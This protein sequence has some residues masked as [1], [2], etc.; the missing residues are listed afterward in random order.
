M[1]ASG[2]MLESKFEKKEESKEIAILARQAAEYVL[3]G[4]PDE[5]EI[6][7]TQNPTVLL[8]SVEVTGPNGLQR[9]TIYELALW[10]DDHHI[11]NKNGQT[12]VEMIRNA[13]LRLPGGREIEKAQRE[14]QYGD[15]KEVVRK[16]TAD[17]AAFNEV[18]RAFDDSTATTMDELIRDAKLQ[19]AIQKFKDYLKPKGII[20]QGISCVTELW[21]YAATTYDT[22]RFVKYGSPKNIFFCQH[23]ISAIDLRLPAWAM[24][25]LITGIIFVI[26]TN[27][28]VARSDVF[29]YFDVCLLSAARMSDDYFLSKYG[30]RYPIDK[31][32]DPWRDGVSVAPGNPSRCTFKAFIN[33]CGHPGEEVL[34]SVLPS[35]MEKKACAPA[36][37]HLKTPLKAKLL[38]APE[39]LRFVNKTSD[40]LA[41]KIFLAIHTF[42]KDPNSTIKQK[43]LND[44]LGSDPANIKIALGYEIE[45]EIP[46]FG[47]ARVTPLVYLI[48]SIK[49]PVDEKVIFQIIEAMLGRGADVNGFEDT[50]RR[51][52]DRM[53]SLPSLICAVAFC[54][55]NIV[56]FLLEHGADAARVN[57]M[58]NCT[59][60]TPLLVA[61][62]NYTKRDDKQDDKKIYDDMISKLLVHGALR[63]GYCLIQEGDQDNVVGYAATKGEI[64]LVKR[65][66]HANELFYVGENEA[67]N[68]KMYG[69]RTIIKNAAKDGCTPMHRAA[70]KGYPEILE[71]LL[72]YNV[73]NSLNG[74]TR[75]DIE[76]KE[77][78]NLWDIIDNIDKRDFG[79]DSLGRTPEERIEALKRLKMAYATPAELVQQPWNVRREAL[80]ATYRAKESFFNKEPAV[81]PGVV[82]SPPPSGASSPGAP[83]AAAPA[84][85]S[86]TA[87]PPR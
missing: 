2:T 30:D 33:R 20:T 4:A 7:I 45:I 9:G 36:G 49:E 11:R 78:E 15:C 81:C 62:V 85:P 18:V 16:I 65:L 6:I 75:A 87:R 31:R 61:V 40:V 12:L 44:L 55:P 5:V 14:A 83:P 67:D 68:D 22:E 48:C 52:S 64:E 46:I 70:L 37:S 82:L 32:A 54:K 77:G 13:V 84:A 29:P 58:R 35:G 42:L 21:D 73:K 17:R 43:E 63:T 80:L 25:V 23:I 53:I 79:D 72:Q 8:C 19:A 24:Q 60:H 86:A 1:S 76:N 74:R 47:V 59:M 57:T 3:W 69:I 50:L 26:K 56:T 39:S 10:T 28:S 34:T 27:A 51:G 66:L 41:K 38:G 71:L